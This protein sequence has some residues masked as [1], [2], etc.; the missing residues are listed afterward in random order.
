MTDK[1]VTFVSLSLATVT[2]PPTANADAGPGTHLVGAGLLIATRDGTRWRFSSEAATISAGEKEQNLLLWLADRLPMADTLIG[3]QIDQH[4]VPAL[5]DAAAHADAAIAHHFTLRLAR[6]LRNTV[7]DMSVDP[8]AA[9]APRAAT[10]VTVP[11]SMAPGALLAA[12]GI[13]RLDAVRADLATEAIGTWL[14]FVGQTKTPG[15]EAQQATRDWM[16]RRRRIA[17]VEGRTA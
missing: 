16:H 1:P 11:P 17:L 9:V 15:M 8:G 6:A 14:A 10:E 7:V 5:I 4:L 13:G 3:W 2:V 12:W